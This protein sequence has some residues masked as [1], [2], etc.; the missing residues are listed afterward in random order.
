[1][2]MLVFCRPR[3]CF[4]DIRCHHLLIRVGWS[5]QHSAR[6]THFVD[7]I[8]IC[9]VTTCLFIDMSTRKTPMWLGAVKEAGD[10][11]HKAFAC[12]LTHVLPKAQQLC[13]PPNWPSE[14][15]AHGWKYLWEKIQLSWMRQLLLNMNTEFET[16]LKDHC[17]Y[18]FL[19]NILMGMSRPNQRGQWPDLGQL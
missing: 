13:T 15:T 12:K 19:A 10:Y 8:N 18:T 9:L 17:M 4:L 16:V 5:N 6:L 1:M 11:L 14:N 2:Y 3:C 7:N